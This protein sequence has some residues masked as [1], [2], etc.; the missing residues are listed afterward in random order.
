[1]RV[2]GIVSMLVG[3]GVIF[4]IVLGLY[5]ERLYYLRDIHASIGILGLILVAYLTYNSFKRGSTGLRIASAITLLITLVQVSLGLHIYI[6]PQILFVNLHLATAI[7]LAIS[8][9]LTGFVSMRSS[10]RGK[11]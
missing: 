7:I 1:M 4:Q 9:A 2:V 8:I 3:I 5:V 6:S 10:R 11:T